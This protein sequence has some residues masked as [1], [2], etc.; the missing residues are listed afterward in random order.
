MWVHR[1]RLSNSLVIF[2]HGIFGSRWTTWKG[3]VDNFQSAAEID[4]VI[5]SYDFYLFQYDSGLRQLPLDP[6]VLD[7]LHRFLRLPD[8]DRKYRT[9]VFVCHSQGGLVAKLYLLRQIERQEAFRIDHVITYGTPHHGVWAATPF[10]WLQNVPLLGRLDPLRQMGQLSP[11]SRN[12]RRLKEHW[13]AKRKAYNATRGADTLGAVNLVGAY[14]KIVPKKSAMGFSEEGV[15]NVPYDHS[16]P[17]TEVE[18]LSDELFLEL[19]G[20]RRPDALLQEVSRI[21]S[22]QTARNLYIHTYL[23][24]VKPLVGTT[25]TLVPLASAYTSQISI[26]L[27]TH[28]LVDIECCPM[29]K[30]SLGEAVQEYVRRRLERSC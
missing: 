29:R 26:D 4:P 22:D 14:D 21:R 2:I 16:I 24:V 20:H 13:V 15:R 11:L 18:A 9:I 27:M 23:P 28:F 10:L 1:H 8:I 6:Y 19:R 3:L 30:V 7:D 5:G 25:A 12:V 17:R